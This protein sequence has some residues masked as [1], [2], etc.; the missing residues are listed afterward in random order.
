[1]ILLV[2]TEVYII[3]N[4]DFKQ[5]KLSYFK[6]SALTWAPEPAV[7]CFVSEFSL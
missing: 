6:N 7:S 2:T 3:F 5:L 4:D 1:M